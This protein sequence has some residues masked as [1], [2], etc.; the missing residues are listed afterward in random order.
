MD[1]YLQKPLNLKQHI[2][3][4]RLILLWS[5]SVRSN[6]TTDSKDVTILHFNDIYNV[7]PSAS[8]PVGGAARFCS[9]IKSYSYLQPLVLFSGDVFSP[10]PLSYFTKGAQMSA[11]LN[12]CGV[13]AAIFGNHDF[14]YGLNVLKQRVE[15]TQFPW[16]LSNVMTD[17]NLTL[18]QSQRT[19]VVQRNNKR[20]GLIGLTEQKWLDVQITIDPVRVHYQDF[21]LICNDL[22]EYLRNQGCDYVIALTHLRMKN[23]IKLA[24]GCPGVDLILGGHDHEYQVIQ[25]N[26]TYIVK[27]GSDFKSLSKIHLQF[28]T[29]VIEPKI[30]EINVTSNIQEDNILKNLLRKY[31]DVLE[32][33]GDK[34][35]LVLSEAMDARV[36]EL[37]RAESSLGNWLSD[38]VLSVTAADIVLLNSG[39]F[40]ANREFP[41]GPFTRQHFAALLP[42]TSAMVM[43]NITGQTVLEMLENA[44]SRYPEP[45]GRFGNVAGVQFSFNPEARM[46][47][48]VIP[49]QVI[50]GAGKLKLDRYYKLATRVYLQKGYDGYTMLQG[51]PELEVETGVCLTL[52]MIIE[53][54]LE[55]L[56]KISKN[57][58][59][60]FH[61][62]TPSNQRHLCLFPESGPI[63]L[64]PKTDK[65]IN[66]CFKECTN[67]N[68]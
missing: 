29:N 38:A 8:E 2:Y 45:D 51:T 63:M 67:I 22:T 53:T 65:R 31:S 25:V 61:L 10:S 40:K 47:Q 28:R 16:I 12:E 64:C 39:M 55:T 11:V 46:G 6:P 7:E 27:S 62:I 5:L 34:Q 21:I 44:V 18:A 66:P 23:D 3:V 17:N 41:A 57:W 14:D 1:H 20:I 50:V 15:E 30:Q 36:N 48:K 9:L 59:K 26:G 43:L 49:H 33:E 58:L 32:R 35:L 52:E 4:C 60:F 68:Q 42:I 13:H 24:E 37:W 19:L 54:Y 56:Q